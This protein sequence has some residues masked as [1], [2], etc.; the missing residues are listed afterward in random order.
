VVPALAVVCSGG[1]GDPEEEEFVDVASEF[2]WAIETNRPREAYALLSADARSKISYERFAREV[3][4]HEGSRTT[5]RVI[6]LFR[7]AGV[8]RRSSPHYEPSFSLTHAPRAPA[9]TVVVATSSPVPGG[10]HAGRG[11]LWLGS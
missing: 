7:E 1:I 8:T 10:P 11:E 9:I 5:L 4:T 3:R 2:H 6:R